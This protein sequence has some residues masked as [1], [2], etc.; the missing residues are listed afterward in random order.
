M[1]ETVER[2]SMDADIV[3]V[4]FGPAAGGFLHTLTQAMAAE[5]EAE[6]FQ[7]R[8]ATGM[9]L[10]ILC[11]E[12]ADD[13]GFGVSGVVTRGRALEA[14]F[15]GLDFKEI[16][17]FA[18]VSG[19]EVLYLLDPVGASR[20]GALL[21]F[22]DACL[23][24]IP[25]LTRDH[26]FKMPII[27]PFLHKG[28]GYVLSLG[29]FTAWIGSQIMSTGLAQIW[30]GSP[31]NCALLDSGKVTGV[32]LC[33]Q[34]VDKSGAPESGY[35]P[36][37]DIRAALTV[38]ADGPVGPVGRQLDEA[39]G[40]RFEGG[41][42][43]EWAAGMKVVVDLPADTP[44]KAG[45]V[46]HTMGFPE[47][48]VFGFLYVYPGNVATA[49]VFVPSWLDD[50][51]RTAYR[52]LQ[53][54]IKHP[55]LYK[56]L[57]GATLR[58]W[59]AKSLLESGQR[60]EPKLCGDGY[61]RI[62][63]GSGST[64]VLTGSG[65]DEAWATGVQLAEGVLELLKAGKPFDKA[66]LEAA[67]VARRRASWVEKEGKVAARSRDGFDRGFLP[68][69]IGMALAGFTGGL[70]NWPGHPRPTAERMPS[71]ESY[72]GCSKAE[73]DALLEKAK[74]TGK[75]MHDDLMDR[76]GW[77]AIEEDGALL[78][79]H[80]D[81]LLMGGKVQA[82]AGFADH[83]RAIDPAL[84][85]GCRSKL[86]VDMCSGQALSVGPE[87]APAFD[88]EKC[89]HCGICFWNCPEYVDKAAGR[90]NI[91]FAAGSGGFHSAEN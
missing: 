19:E 40:M 71:P 10:Q 22:Q 16:P 53:Q 64:N 29:Q 76:A 77:P 12:R 14:S 65:V 56:H 25:G 18:P 90:T 44:L 83:V 67:Y 15:P 30:P 82:A 74:A 70:L 86:C 27:P 47:P 21:K 91:S 20:R 23:K 8:V 26:A 85:L 45:H 81:A 61:A 49:G 31:V 52:T 89:V 75:G 4:G 37:M 28:D 33:D 13:L 72:H 39:F 55:R 7:S 3:C 78:V 32:R 11:Y 36:G 42:K 57:K 6:A 60:G 79:S 68:G 84:C 2:Q 9:P 58:S 87:G 48:G 46:L 73:I 1:E 63:E 34:G 17:L 59:G 51:N 80:Q 38:V 43:D 69:A 66:S 5:P 50:P 41:S 35:M 88:R 54:W 24:L 62:G